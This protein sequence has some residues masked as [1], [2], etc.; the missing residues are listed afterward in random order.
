MFLLG[1]G[2]VTNA[3][4]TAVESEKGFVSK[5]STVNPIEFFAECFKTYISKT[6]LLERT[7][8]EMFELFETLNQADSMESLER[9]F[10]EEDFDKYDLKICFL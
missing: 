9:P 3:Y 5:Y 1:L 6:D 10:T 8:P 2:H 4:N 7:N